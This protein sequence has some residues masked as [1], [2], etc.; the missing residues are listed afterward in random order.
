MV[1]QQ[2]AMTHTNNLALLLTEV[3]QQ[4]QEQMQSQQ[5]KK[6]GNK[7]K[8]GKPKKQCKSG[9]PS[10]KGK[11]GEKG[12][13]GMDGLQKNL[14]KSME[15][16]LKDMKD[17]KQPGSK[18]FAI[19]AAQQEALR[20]EIERIEKELRENGG[21]ELSDELSETQKMMEQTEKELYNKKLSEQTLK[22]Q[23]DIEHRLFEHE[24]AEREQGEKEE[25]KGETATEVERKLPP[26]I[27]QYLKEKAKEIE[28]YRTLPP[29]FT[30][31]YRDRVKEYFRT[32]Q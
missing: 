20:K 13:K 7:Q 21:K 19:I 22:R 3:L 23:R 2:Y 27:E 5:D 28:F 25:R 4:M 12:L 29:E 30:P 10:N 32:I 17:G 31:Y 11:D 18:E 26:S 9:K 1:N 16:L 14:S 15:Q 6:E 8:Q 24:K